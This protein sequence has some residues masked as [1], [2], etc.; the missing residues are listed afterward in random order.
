[1]TLADAICL[2]DKNF[3]RFEALLAKDTDRDA[4]KDQMRAIVEIQLRF[5]I[6][7]ALKTGVSRSVIHW[8]V[9]EEADR[10]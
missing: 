8:F 3:H 7:L 1:M 10:C 5:A 9:D 6:R 4:G 2:A